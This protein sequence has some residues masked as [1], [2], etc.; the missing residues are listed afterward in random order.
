MRI[1]R[2]GGIVEF[3]CQITQLRIYAIPRV[4]VTSV[5]NEFR[6]KDGT[7]NKDAFHHR[8][9]ESQSEARQMNDFC[10]A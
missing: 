6:V 5:V 3:N 9:T 7:A 8:D 10:G 2:T 1:T 4:S